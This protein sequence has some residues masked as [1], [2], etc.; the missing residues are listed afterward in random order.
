MKEKTL[1]QQIYTS[2][3]D[4]TDAYNI[5]RDDLIA[6]GVLWKGSKLDKV[7]CIYKR[8]DP[9]SALTGTLAYFDEDK[10]DRN[11]HFPSLFLP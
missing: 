4:V 6:L 11:I 5:V 1:V 10:A 7:Q 8:V 9:R 3:E 2:F